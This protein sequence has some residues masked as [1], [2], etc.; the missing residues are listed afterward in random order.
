[1]LAQAAA[2]AQIDWDV[3]VIRLVPSLVLMP[4]TTNADAPWLGAGQ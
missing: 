4:T 3:A 1:M 2:L